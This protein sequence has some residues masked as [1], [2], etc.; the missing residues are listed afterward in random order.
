MKG[1]Q[2]KPQQKIQGKTGA[3]GMKFTS[4]MRIDCKNH[5]GAMQPKVT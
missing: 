3:L 4:E 2:A 1:N 5:V